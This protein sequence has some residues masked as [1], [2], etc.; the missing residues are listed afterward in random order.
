MKRI[1]QLI[2]TLQNKLHLNVV[3]STRDEIMTASLPLAIKKSYAV[4]FV[5]IE[6]IEVAVLS[7]DELKT[8]GLQKHLELYDRA[9]AL[10]LLLNITEGNSALQKFL[11]DKNIAFVMGEDTVYMP[12]F[13]IWI[14]DL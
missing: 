12:Q 7:V 9:L 14:K 2:L 11:I 8:A 5:L 3:R 6:G 4:D 10:P 1:S 13:L